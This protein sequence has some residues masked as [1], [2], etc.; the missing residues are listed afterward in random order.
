MKNLKLTGKLK[1]YLEWPLALLALWAALVVILY[2]YVGPVAAAIGLVFMVIYAGI[3]IFQYMRSTP[4]LMNEMVAFATQY[5]QVQKKLLKGFNLP[6]ALLDESGNFLWMN[7]AFAAISGKEKNYHRNI[8]ALFEE[9]TS[10]S[11]PAGTE[12]KNLTIERDGRI[13]RTE[14]TRVYL[15]EL[16]DEESFLRGDESEYLIAVLLFDETE[17]MR[18]RQEQEDEQ[19]VCGLLSIDNYDEALEG[20]EDVRRSLLLALAERKINKYFSEM[21]VIIRKQSHERF[22]FVMK[23]GSL[24][25]CEE[26]RFSILDDVKT[27]NL[28][29]ELS[30]TISMGI[31]YGA[32][33][34]TANAETAR[35]AMELALGRGGDQAVVKDGVRTYFYGGNTESTGKSTRVK[36][37]V[38]AHALQEIIEQKNRVVVMGHRLADIDALGAAIGIYCAAKKVGRPA[39]ILADDVSDSVRPVIEGFRN[40]REYD[41]DMFI[42]KKRAKELTGADTVLVV[43]DTNKPNYT[44][45]P[46]LLSLTNSIVVFDHHRQGN[47][48]IENTALSYLEPYAS[49]ACEMVAEV[50]QYFSDGLK[51]RSAEADAMFAGIV[52]DTNNFVTRTGARTFDAAAYLRRNGADVTRVRKMFREEA[53]ELKAKAQ[54]VASAEIFDD[55]Y[56]ISVCPSEGLG[57]PT[58]VSAQ[59]ANELL[60]IIG[61]RATF[62]LTEYNSQIFISARAIDEV[63]VQLIMERLGGGGHLNIAGAQLPDH[64]IEEAIEILKETIREMKEEGDIA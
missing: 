48:R 31:G 20:V 52:V 27:V 8:T 15:Q 2:I 23:K 38:K 45:C 49:S 39:F 54:A 14:M 9:V 60:N 59:A 56:A 57:S 36:A 22:F 50:L 12:S 30:L 11:L 6:Y 7:D 32:D 18:L 43:V 47:E 35:A 34:F 10:D 51:L 64:T 19:I 44:A 28:G 13:Y 29:N 25:E 17:L 62:V 21:D 3:V 37:R 46:E 24:K 63:N 41:E 16:L 4:R 5:G 33:T 55:V 61:I 42:D 58:V 26:E 1:T 53:P 40:D